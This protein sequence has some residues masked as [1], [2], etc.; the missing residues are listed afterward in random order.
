MTE[1]G[2]LTMQ[3]YEGYIENGQFHPIGQPMRL[4]GRHRVVLTVLDEPVASSKVDRP[5][6]KWKGS[7]SALDNPIQVPD[8]KVF[9]R[10]ELH[11][12]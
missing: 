2:G 6:K 9:T 8:F 4:L 10:E 12:R 1:E 7:L 5:P 3:A 11:E